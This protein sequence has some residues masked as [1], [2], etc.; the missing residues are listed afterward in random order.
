MASSSFTAGSSLADDSTEKG[1]RIAKVIARA[2]I[3]SRR[4][5]EKL[6][7]EGR[8]ALDG[9]TV[10]TQGV[11]VGENQVVSVDGKPLLEPD[12]ARLWRYHKPSGLVTTHKDPQGRPTVF[13]NLPKTLPRV[14][15]IGRLD[16][17]SEGL[18]LLTN[19]GEIARRLELPIAGWT[20]KYRV[21]LFGKVSQ[22]ELDR[23]AEGVTIAGVKYGPIVADIER[24]KGVYSWAG[25]TLKEGKN[26]EVKRV[27]ESLGL[28]VARLIRV[29]FGPFHL[30]QLP[31]GAVEEIPAK[32][33]REHM[34]IGRKKHKDSR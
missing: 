2:G 14:V 13:A 15:S 24:T 8:V 33:W 25:V 19:D 4:D 10:T 6:I 30:G 27:M 16:F 31:E 22:A 29:Q 23:L 12:A 34:G 5:A 11:K 32:L 7:A 28:K 21:R 9:K 20:R 26:R 3:C 18:L 17:N 1:E